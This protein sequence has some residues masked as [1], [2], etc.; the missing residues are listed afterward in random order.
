MRTISREVQLAW[1]AGILDGE[2]CLELTMKKAGNGK[3]YLSPKIRIYNTDIRMIEKASMIYEDH[4][5]VFFYTLGNN[6]KSTSVRTGKPWKTQIGICIAS[7]GTTKK[8]LE[9]VLPYLCNKQRLASIMIE[10]INFVAKC[11]K[12]GNTFRFE[13]AETDEFKRLWEVYKQEKSFYMDPSTTARRANKRLMIQS[14]LGSD[15]E[16]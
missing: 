1:L 5:L 8:L 11:P 3:R 10:M 15:A 2:G 7:Q 6:G 9:L 13:Y 4:N 16:R 12:G 14:E